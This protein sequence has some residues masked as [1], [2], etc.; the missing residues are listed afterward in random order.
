MSRAR[1]RPLTAASASSVAERDDTLGT[2]LNA[3]AHA[4]NTTARVFDLGAYE[5]D[6]HVHVENNIQQGTA[7][8]SRTLFSDRLRASQDA[9]RTA[10]MQALTYSHI[11]AAP[12][13]PLRP[14]DCMAYVASGDDCEHAVIISAPAQTMAAAQTDVRSSDAMPSGPHFN[15]RVGVAQAEIA[16]VHAELETL[17][18]EAMCV[19]IAA[20]SAPA[21]HPLSPPPSPP[22]SS[23]RFP[24]FASLVATPI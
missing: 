15:R 7:L 24:S 17:R 4:A 19:R 22:P 1:V 8:L 20:Q 2:W 14:Y 23:F 16:T 6:D 3:S 9:A 11:R 12:S 21:S 18:A 10:A 5:N 13:L